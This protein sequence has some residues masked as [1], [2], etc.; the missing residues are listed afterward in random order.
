MSFAELHSGGRGDVVYGAHLLCLQIDTGSFETMLLGKND[1][2][3]F[4]K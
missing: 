3:I 2:R 4:S 1:K